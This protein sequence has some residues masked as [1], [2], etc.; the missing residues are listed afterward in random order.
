MYEP[1]DTEY[2]KIKFST[3]IAAL[4]QPCCICSFHWRTQTSISQEVVAYFVRYKSTVKR[5][6]SHLIIA[7]K[8]KDLSI[9]DVQ[10]ASPRET[11]NPR[12]VGVPK[13]LRVPAFRLLRYF[14]M[15]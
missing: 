15:R 2:G 14:P 10:V 11:W 12:V 8:A 4:T 5:N 9:L 1:Q 3:D 13:A 6:D 7:S